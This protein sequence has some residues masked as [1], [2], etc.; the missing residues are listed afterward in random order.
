VNQIELHPFCQQ[1]EIVQWCRQ[2]GIVVEAYCP[3]MRGVRWNDET[4]Q[5]IAQKYGKTVPQ[6]LIRWSLQMGSAFS[7][8][9]PRRSLLTFLRFSPLPK[10]ANAY[11]VVSNAQVFDFQLEE[12]D[13]D[14][15][16]ALDEGDKGAVSWNPIHAP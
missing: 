16:A 10:S 1:R 5:A 3:L 15:I 11:R 4:L 14:K 2:N 12:D 13:M 8:C 6:V 9:L 7:R